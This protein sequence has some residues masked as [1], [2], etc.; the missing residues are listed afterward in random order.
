MNVKV[1]VLN[2]NTT[3]ILD[4]NNNLI[5]TIDPEEMSPRFVQLLSRGLYIEVLEMVLKMRE[6]RAREIRWILEELTSEKTEY[7]CA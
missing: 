2:D 5:A 3:Q 7:P 6:I 1:Q 4:G